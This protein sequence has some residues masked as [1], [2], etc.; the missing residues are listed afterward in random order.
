G[1]MAL[2]QFVFDTPVVMATGEGN[3]DLKNEQ[4]DLAVTGHPKR[5]QLVRVRPPIT[6]K[7]PL[8]HPGIGVDARSAIVQGGIAA[9]VAVVLSP[10]GGVLTLV[11]P[12]LRT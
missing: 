8:D 2:R 9:G 7:G 3:V 12:G 5:P 10:L 1:V 4:I 6:I 11:Y